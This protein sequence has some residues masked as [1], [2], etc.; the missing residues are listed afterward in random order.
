M[1]ED[2]KAYTDSIAQQAEAA[3]QRLIENMTPAKAINIIMEGIEIIK[4]A[5]DPE[6][7]NVGVEIRLSLVV[8]WLARHQEGQ[9]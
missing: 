6:G 1:S 4:D 5:P 7:A 2:F 8:T 3:T 9:A